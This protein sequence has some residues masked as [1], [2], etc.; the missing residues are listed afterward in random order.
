MKRNRI[1]IVLL[2]MAASFGLG[3][4]RD[5]TVTASPA[6]FQATILYYHDP[7]HPEYR[8]DRPGKAPDCGM[9]LVPVYA[10]EAAPVPQTRD[11]A[12]TVQGMFRIAAGAQQLIGVK[13]GAAEESGGTVAL[14]TSGRVVADEARVYRLT[15]KV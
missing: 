11:N 7:M 5:R 4:W 10:K 2:L 1:G 13:V 8:S 15:P 3:R 14:R 6:V 9:D 12:D